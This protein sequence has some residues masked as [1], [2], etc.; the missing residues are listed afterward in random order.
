MSL[1]LTIAL[2]LFIFGVLIA[3]HELGHYLVA[4]FFGVGI[5]EYSI[6]MGP[7]VFQKQGKYNKFTLRALPIGGYVDMVGESSDD[8]GSAPEDAGKA[9]LN[10][11]PVWQRI[12]VVLAGPVMNIL[13]GL[14]VMAIIVLFRAEIY[15]TTVS[16]FDV[17]AVSNHSLLY[18]TEDGGGLKKDDII[19]AV[20]GHIAETNGNAAEF[21]KAHP[22]AEE[23]IIIR[24]NSGT[25]INPLEYGDVKLSALP[26]VYDEEEKLFKLSEDSGKFKKDDIIYTVDG[27]DITVKEYDTVEA[28][29]TA[30]TKPYTVGI[31][32]RF[33]IYTE[34]DYAEHSFKSLADFPLYSR[35]G[36]LSFEKD[37]G[38]IKHNA[39]LLKVNGVEI[40]P[41]MT[42]EEFFA[43]YGD[44]GGTVTVKYNWHFYIANPIVLNDVDLTKLSLAA[45]GAL[46]EGDEIVKVGSYGSRVY[47][48]L[49]YGVF[50][51]GV[52]PADV[53]VIRDGKELT[54]KNVVFH[55]VNQQGITCG[56]VDFYTKQEE[57]TFGTVAY[58]A[59]FQPVSTLTMTV[60]S[61]IQTFKGKYGIDAL[62]G[63]VGIGEQ[64]GDAIEVMDSDTGGG[65]EYLFTLLVLIS[66]SLGV[67]NLLPLPVLDGGRFV[68]YVIEGIRRKPLPA[69]VE[70]VLMAISWVLVMG[71][72][73]FVLF[74][75]IWKVAF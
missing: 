18:V 29:C 7:K 75:D 27:T 40:D 32:R 24:R 5:R 23:L 70:Q 58:N 61:V 73:V 44:K 43:Q 11:K 13:L 38:D 36:V 15:G 37:F 59:V 9:P 60:D 68:L 17:N 72:M 49:S 22:H 62:S 6:G 4:R 52:G 48:D 39:Q 65:I 64:V 26:L 20:D 33:K 28:L 55:N 21:I 45:S 74:K 53:K 51:E 57:K 14:I 66:L 25:I 2:T 54:L 50:N 8:D 35:D 42:P 12:L 3:I 63:P 31:V 46:K 71:L 67:C 16:K 47:T 34:P 10:T 19:Y 69:K 1:I 41:A 56:Y 30:Y